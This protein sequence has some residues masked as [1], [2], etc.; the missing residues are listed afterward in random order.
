TSYTWPVK[1]NLPKDGG[2]YEKV[3]FMG[4]FR[5]LSQSRLDELMRLARDG[6]IED[7]GF[8]DEILLGWSGIKTGT[9]EEF[10][11]SGANQ[12]ILLDLFPGLRGAIV[13]AYQESLMGVLR[14]N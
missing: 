4:E 13:L 14:K 2:K 9:G 5:R 11:Y 12:R 1:Y 6:Q 8:V 10:E 7:S 3:E